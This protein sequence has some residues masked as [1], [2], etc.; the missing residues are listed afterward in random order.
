MTTRPRRGW[1]LRRLQSRVLPRVRLA[2]PAKRSQ[3]SSD[4]RRFCRAP[5]VAMNAPHFLSAQN[6]LSRNIIRGND[7]GKRPPIPILNCIN[8]WQM[9]APGFYHSPYVIMGN[10]GFRVEERSHSLSRLKCFVSFVF[11]RVYWPLPKWKCSE[12]LVC[13]NKNDMLKTLLLAL[14][15]AKNLGY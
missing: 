12:C 8:L 3:G 15:I 4:P 7:W 9:K 13:D 6:I 10:W 1:L 2:A 5:D 11:Y 14:H